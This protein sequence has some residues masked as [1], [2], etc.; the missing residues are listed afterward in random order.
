[1]LVPSERLVDANGKLELSR[2]T[3]QA[4]G[5]GLA[6]AVIQAVGAPLAIL[7]DAFSFLA[8]ACLLTRINIPEVAPPPRAAGSSLRA[9]V[10]EGVRILLTEPLLRALAGCAATGN[11]FAYAQAAVLVLYVTRDLELPAPVYA[12]MLTAFG[13]GGIGGA[14]AAAPVGSRLGPAVTIFAG[15]GLVAA[16]DILV[17]LAGPPLPWAPALLVVGQL[18]TGAGL[19][20][21]TVNALSLRQATTPAHHLG[22]LDATSRF[23]A[24]GTLPL[25]ALL[26]GLLGEVIGLRATLLIAATGSGLALLWL[27]ASPLRTH[28]MTPS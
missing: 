22:R 27:L 1:V 13:V 5:P 6:G 25:G 14:L 10:V 11:L 21:F 12:A 23:I 8:S 18:L 2:W 28:K 16:G 17:A 4:A 15:A 3:A 9:E 7:A 19:P 26:G 20:L 24:R